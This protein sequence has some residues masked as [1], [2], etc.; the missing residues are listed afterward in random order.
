MPELNPQIKDLRWGPDQCQKMDILRHPVRDPGGNPWIL[1]RHGGSGNIRDKRLPWLPSGNG[2]ALAYYVNTIAQGVHFDFISVETRQARWNTPLTTHTKNDDFGWDSNALGRAV[3]FPYNW[4]EVQLAVMAVKA[5]APELGINPSQGAGMGTSWGADAMLYSQIARPLFSDELSAQIRSRYQLGGGIDSRLRGVVYHEGHPDLRNS[6]QEA[7]CTMGVLG[8]TYTDATRRLTLT[9]AFTFFDAAVA[10]GVIQV[11][12]GTGANLGQFGVDYVDPA[13]AYIVV[14]RSIGA[15]ADSQTDIR[16]TFKGYPQGID[17]TSATYTSSTQTIT[18]T[19]A[20]AV[21]GH[22]GRGLH[23]TAGTGA[24]EGVYPIASRTSADA[25]TL[26]TSTT[27]ATTGSS[28]LAATIR[29]D[30]V[31]FTIEQDVFGA[32]AQTDYDKVHRNIKRAASALWYIQNRQTQWMPP[33]Y[34]ISEKTGNHRKPYGLGTNGDNHDSEQV[35]TLLAAAAA[36]NAPV[37]GYIPDGT[38]DDSD[39]RRDST[40]AAVFNFCASALSSTPRP[41]ASPFGVGV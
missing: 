19:G 4:Q 32:Y 20:F 38:W 33:V 39:L 24:V 7:A 36:V 3:F 26:N 12:S 35:T 40:S 16:I 8:L 15:G 21:F 22:G 41:L 2:N 14:E 29:G 34:A 17:L 23:L 5:R 28:N 37:S 13:G 9:G 31:T 30:A 11:V 6:F 18:K 27:I 25:I 1:Y 10:G